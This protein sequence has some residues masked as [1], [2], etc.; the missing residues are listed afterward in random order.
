MHYSIITIPHSDQRYQT[1]GDYFLKTQ[2]RAKLSC[3]MVSKMGNEDYEFLIGIH[4]LVEQYL[5]R[6]RGIKEEDITAFD[7]D[8]ENKRMRGLVGFTD[9]PGDDP[10]APYQNEHSFATAVERMVAAAL[11]V[12]W[13]DYEKAINNLYGTPN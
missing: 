2:G 6:K 10:S 12:K 13:A 9:E 1:A 3:I 11:G 8:F 7:L 4:E 5:T